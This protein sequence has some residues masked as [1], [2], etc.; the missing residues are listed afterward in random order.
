MNKKEKFCYLY[1]LSFLGGAF[2]YFLF[3]YFSHLG[4][5]K[6]LILQGDALEQSISTIKCFYDNLLSGTGVTYSWNN[7]QGGINFLHTMVNGMLFSISA[8]FYFIFYKFDYA[9]I[10]LV[11]LT[12]KAGLASMF[13][14]IFMEKTWQIKGLNALVFSVLYATCAFQIAYVPQVLT[15]EDAVFMLPL[16]LYL[17]SVYAENGKIILL[18]LAY[19][20]QFLNVFYMGFIIG[21]FSLLYLIFYM[22]IYKKYSFDL[23]IKKLLI[24]GIYVLLTIGLSAFVLYPIARFILT[25]YVNNNS[26]IWKNLNVN[27]FSIFNQIFIGQNNGV[28]MEQPYIYC[29]LPTI[30]MIPFYF[31][32]KKING[33]EKI[34]I[35]VLLGTMSISCFAKPL[36]Y[37]WHCFDYPDGFYFRFSFVFS[38][39]LCFIA[40]R[41][42]A[43]IKDIKFGALLCWALFLIAFY[44]GFMKLAPYFPT[45]GDAFHNNTEEYMIINLLFVMIYFLLFLIWGFIQK[46]MYLTRIFGGLLLIT[47]VSEIIINGYS[48]YFKNPELSP[49]RYYSA[50]KKWEGYVENAV[51]DIKNQD[52][53]FGRIACDKDYATYS[54]YY[55]NYN[56]VASFS[57]LENANVRKAL[58]DLGIATSP[59]I[60]LCNGLTDFSRMLLDIKYDLNGI[61]F[62]LRKEYD[63]AYNPEQPYIT[64]NYSLGLGFIVE[65][66]LA[67]FEFSGTNQFNNINDLVSCMTGK[68]SVLFDILS[69]GVSYDEYGVALGF[70]ESNRMMF[71]YNPISNNDFGMMVFKIPKEERNAFV[72]FDYGV[73]VH[74]K[75][76]PYIANAASGT[77]STYERISMSYIASMEELDDSY[78]VTIYMNNNTAS[79]AYVPN[80]Y[81][82]YYNEDAFLATYD[83]L[84]EGIMEIEEYKNGYVRGRVNVMED[85]KMLFTSI[86]YEEGWEI[87]VNGEPTD[88]IRVI[89]DAFIGVM[90]KKGEYNIEFKYHVPGLKTGTIVSLISLAIFLASIYIGLQ[91]RQKNLDVV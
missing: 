8:P 16:I 31:F 51:N 28:Y 82:A 14:Y 64:N 58:Y 63:T 86:P 20:Y 13:F 23:C 50:F 90:L 80:V 42:S 6:F 60:I 27:I 79:Q 65:D 26:N 15:Y 37:F 5:G 18:C 89:D 56:G 12:L 85:G 2:S 53:D 47:V 48:A 72:Q 77:I 32:N 34:M 35:A 11:I 25:Q 29:G 3:M 24:F 30:L 59:R 19:L 83:V 33:K 7:F 69:S 87:F 46:R 49:D 45:K 70:D 1:F 40:C 43:Y 21:I 9:I 44:F 10:T 67:D 17:V 74:D 73:S 54:S 68:E 61:D 52:S 39:I 91:K 71:M 36:Y 4:D 66:N 38:F 81:F 88:P 62:P 41:Q 76:S 55:F 75:S 78:G 84:K 57:S 22:A